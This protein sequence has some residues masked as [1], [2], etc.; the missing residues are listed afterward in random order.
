MQGGNQIFTDGR[1]EK[2]KM[3]HLSEEMR[4]VVSGS[5]NINRD[6]MIFVPSKNPKEK[7]D[8]SLTHK[9]SSDKI[10][11]AQ[12]VPDPEAGSDKHTR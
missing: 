12:S 11:I 9:I 1:S 2:T 5:M 3:Q 6:Q 8:R 10:S 7:E 4:V